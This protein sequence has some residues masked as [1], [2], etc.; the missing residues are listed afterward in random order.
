MTSDRVAREFIAENPNC[1]RCGR[2]GVQC[3]E[4]ACGPA[5]KKARQERCSMLALCPD[6][7][8][9]VHDYSLWPIARQ[10]ALK[11]IRDPKHFDPERV[12]ELRGRSRFAIELFEIVEFLEMPI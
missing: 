9:K 2:Y 3:H 8:R 6:C 4:I 7:H 10:L 11:L 12:N 1:W 5:R